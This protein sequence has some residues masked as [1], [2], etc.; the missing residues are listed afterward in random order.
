MGD[1]NSLLLERKADKIILDIKRSNYTRGNT[2]IGW[3]AGIWIVEHLKRSSA[4][5]YVKSGEVNGKPFWWKKFVVSHEPHS[6]RVVSIKSV[7]RATYYYAVYLFDWLS[8]LRTWHVIYNIQ[9]WIN[10]TALTLQYVKY[11]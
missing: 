10:S 3:S 5:C 2:Y 7:A 8:T 4:I 1:N 9:H 6:T 11:R